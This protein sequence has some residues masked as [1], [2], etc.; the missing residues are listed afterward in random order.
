MADDGHRM[1][2]TYKLPPIE[3]YEVTDEQLERI[4]ES[5]QTV[6]QDFAF[7]LSS[8][9]IFLSFAVALTSANPSGFARTSYLIVAG[10]SAVVCL[11]TGSRWLRTRQRTPTTIEK[12]R[13]RKVDPQTLAKP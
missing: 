7:A 3:I 13:S 5:C 2:R 6:G 4:E 11:Y 8:L 1:A 9:S 12:I 10:I